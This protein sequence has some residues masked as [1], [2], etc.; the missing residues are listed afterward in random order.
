MKKDL[1]GTAHKLKPNRLA[2]VI[3]F[4]LQPRLQLRPDLITTLGRITFYTPP[5]CWPPTKYSLITYRVDA[6]QTSKMGWLKDTFA[7]KYTPQLPKTVNCI[8][9]L[10]LSTHWPG[11]CRLFLVLTTTRCLKHIMML[12]HG[13]VFLRC[14]LT[15]CTLKQKILWLR[16]KA[17]DWSSLV[18]MQSLIFC[19]ARS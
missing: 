18:T 6:S 4:G 11:I 17:W 1:G 3:T 10:P 12:G 8:Y 2:T 9:F 7:D 15:L 16:L 14:S 19:S 5:I 13:Y